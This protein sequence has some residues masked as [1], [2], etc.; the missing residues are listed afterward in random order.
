MRLLERR[1]RAMFR[2]TGWDECDDDAARCVRKVEEAIE[3]LDMVRRVLRS[4]HA[5]GASTERTSGVL[6]TEF[7][8]REKE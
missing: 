3:N 5:E 4:G 7:P 1:V 6:P 8:N 2:Y